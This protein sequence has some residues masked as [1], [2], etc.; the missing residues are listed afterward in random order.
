MRRWDAAVGPV[1]NGYRTTI[2]VDYNLWGGIG[3]GTGGG[4]RIHGTIMAL[5]MRSGRSG[6]T[7]RLGLDRGRELR[8]RLIG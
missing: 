7:L 2:N 4:E 8:A 6:F 1:P 3:R 5:M